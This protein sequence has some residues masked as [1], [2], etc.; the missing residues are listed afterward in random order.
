VLDPRLLDLFEWIAKEPRLYAEVT[1][2]W[3]TSCS[4]RPIW[5]TAMDRRNLRRKRNDPGVNR[6]IVTRAGLALRESGRIDSI[7]KLIP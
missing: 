6:V 4:R 3:R 1:E 2:A 5:E 7:V